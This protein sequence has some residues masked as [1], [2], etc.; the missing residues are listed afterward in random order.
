MNVLSRELRLYK[1]SSA[2]IIGITTPFILVICLGF[3]I[4]GSLSNVPVGL[5]TTDS[6][7]SNQITQIFRNDSSINI[8]K[9]NANSL[10]NDLVSGQLRAA[11][12]VNLIHNKNISITIFVDSTDTA[13]KQQVQYSIT[14]L[15]YQGLSKDG[16]FV[17]INTKEL[18]SGKSF[19]TYLMPSILVLGPVLGGLFGATDTILNE[20]EDTTLENVIVAG[21]SPIKFA[22][23][24]IVS[25]FLTTSITLVLTFVTVVI[26]SGSIPSFSQIVI[27]FVFIFVSAFIF[28]AFGVGL[29]TYIPNK[30]IA[31]TIGGTIMF[32]ILFVSGAFLSVY[33][34]IGFIVP[35]AKLN[36]LTICTESLRT[37]LLKNG[38]IDD[39]LMNFLSLTSFAIVLFLFAVYRMNKIINAMQQ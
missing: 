4:T 25:F 6:T 35:I 2:W 13:I 34:M 36:P 3:T 8:H 16:Y 21:F 23:E 12:S 32:P 24:K 33:S 1:R 18:F 26:F 19:F 29:S 5:S 17:T 39:V 11:I 28:I 37:I 22:M 7:V 30:E 31:G 27:S 15:L 38:S 20:K 14:T 9:I 10:N